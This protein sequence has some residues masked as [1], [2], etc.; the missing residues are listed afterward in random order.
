MGIER[1][2]TYLVHPHKGSKDKPNIG[3]TTVSLSGKLF[4]LLDNIFSNSDAELNIQIAF[5]QSADGKQQNACRDLLIAYVQ[6]PTLPNG[7]RLAE[8]LASV[9]DQ[10]TGLGLLF[11]IVGKEGRNHKIVISRFPTDTAILAEEKRASLTVEFLERVFMKSAN[12]YKAV[13]YVDSSSGSGSFWLGRAVDKQINSPLTEVSN[14][15]I[16]DFLD[17]GF[18]VTGAAGTRRLA[19]A[20]REAAK[21]VDDI[22]IKTEIVAAATLARGLRGRRTSIAEFL[23]Q[24]HLSPA[25]TDAILSE[26]KGDSVATEQFQ[27]DAEEFRTQVG[28]RSVE[29]NNGGMLTAEANEFDNVFR[30]E[31]TGRGNVRFSTEG[32]IVNDKLRKSR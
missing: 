18:Q 16:V 28:F 31:E 15:W 2:H 17:S 6:K 7:R 23:S 21:K 22:D 27:F 3:G 24:F 32:R 5:N 11:L 8:R 13:A 26:L 1:I 4:R 29:L 30:K 20:I 25:A 12:S 14:Y 19:A 10:R 9:S